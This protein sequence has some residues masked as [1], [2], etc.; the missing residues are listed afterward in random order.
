MSKS[1]GCERLYDRYKKDCPCQSCVDRRRSNDV[2]QS[3][4]TGKACKEKNHCAICCEIRHWAK[5]LRHHGGCCSQDSRCPVCD[6]LSKPGQ[7]FNARMSEHSKQVLIKRI[8]WYML[9]DAK[10]SMPWSWREWTL[11]L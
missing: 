4:I 1:A 7:E 8:Y 5:I 10:K 11:H 3:H 2:Y 6:W 9:C